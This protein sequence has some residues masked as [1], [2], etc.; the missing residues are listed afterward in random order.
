MQKINEV[1]QSNPSASESEVRPEKVE[2]VTQLYHDTEV[3][4]LQK[5]ISEMV[6][7][8]RKLTKFD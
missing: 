5:K 1:S 8:K 6:Y 2:T 7:F 4:E 3:N